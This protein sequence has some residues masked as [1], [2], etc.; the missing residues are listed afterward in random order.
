ML[1]LL[2][3][4]F[5]AVRHSYNTVAQCQKAVTAYFCNKQILLFDFAKLFNPSRHKTLNQ[6][7]I[8]VGPSSPTLDQR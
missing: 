7:W 4:A 3:T 1:S 2:P 8:N 6:C 5:A